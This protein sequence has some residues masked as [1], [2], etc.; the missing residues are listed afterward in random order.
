MET[1]QLLA[2][3]E[4]FIGPCD[5]PDTEKEIFRQIISMAPAPALESIIEIFSENPLVISLFIQNVTKKHAAQ[6]DL[7]KMKELI[8]EDDRIFDALLTNIKQ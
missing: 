1:E 6:G 8:D 3:V 5:L 4:T 7:I 2:Q